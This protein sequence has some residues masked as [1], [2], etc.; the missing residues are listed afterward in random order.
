[1]DIKVLY[2][3]SIYDIV[4]GYYGR[5][6]NLYDVV[7]NNK[8]DIFGDLDNLVSEGDIITLDD[9]LII[10]ST[11]KYQTSDIPVG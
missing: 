11:N 10:T 9:N 1:M 5:L 2:N 7:K 4:L 6:D 3:Q 8:L